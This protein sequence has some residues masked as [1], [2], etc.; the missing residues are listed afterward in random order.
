MMTKPQTVVKVPFTPDLLIFGSGVSQQPVDFR[1]KA[2]TPERSYEDRDVFISS[3]NLDFNIWLRGEDAITL[4]QLLIEHGQKALLANMIQHQHIHHI[5]ILKR[6]I[7]EDRVEKLIY[8]VI[9]DSVPNY[10][11][12][13][14][15]HN[16]YP[17][18]KEGKAPE[19]D[20]DFSFETAIYWSP[21]DNEFNDQ[22]K[23]FGVPSEILNYDREQDLK[24]F[25]EEMKALEDN[26]ET[27]EEID[28]RLKALTEFINSEE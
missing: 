4:G 3:E 20:E 17:I 14:R 22:K 6:Y 19:Y 7:S 26:Q 28:E 2:L 24:E 13:W 12:G 16:L 27:P 21:F 10:G 9:D 11:R 15:L 1:I 23:I 5:N 8:E 25:E 18:W